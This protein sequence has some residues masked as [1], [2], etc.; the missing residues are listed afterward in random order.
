MG[1]SAAYGRINSS[2]LTKCVRAGQCLPAS[3]LSPAPPWPAGWAEYGD[4]APLFNVGRPL[5][6]GHVKYS[7]FTR[8]GLVLL[9]FFICLFSLHTQQHNKNLSTSL[10]QFTFL[11]YLS[12]SIIVCGGQLLCSIIYQTLL[13]SRGGFYLGRAL[14]SNKVPQ[15]PFVTVFELFSSIMRP[16]LNREGC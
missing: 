10:A 15:N 12:K 6:R 5:S 9:V 8:A 16:G 7:C 1:L 4:H 13:S 3:P 2:F 11:K 14:E